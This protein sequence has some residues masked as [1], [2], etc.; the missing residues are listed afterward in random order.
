M[1]G[2]VN[3]LAYHQAP[4][5][6]ADVQL[7][8]TIE[9]LPGEQFVFGSHQFIALFVCHQL[10]RPALIARRA[11]DDGL[12]TL[13]GFLCSSGSLMGRSQSTLAADVV[14]LACHENEQTCENNG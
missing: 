3:G 10:A 12:G 14:I 13:L 6:P 5:F 4:T 2:I 7:I 8:A 1:P 11:R 9:V